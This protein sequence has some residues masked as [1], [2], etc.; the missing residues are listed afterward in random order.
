M[1]ALGAKMDWEIQQMAV[2]P[3]YLNGDL[4]EEIYMQQPEGYAEGPEVCHLMKTLYGLKQS[5]QAW[6]KKIHGDFGALLTNSDNCVYV[7][8]KNGEKCIVIMYIDDIVLLSSS[9]VERESADIFT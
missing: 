7:H 5:G 6:Y 2:K 4:D 1:L 3:A 9:Q 8:E